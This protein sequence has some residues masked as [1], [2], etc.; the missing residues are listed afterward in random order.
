MS[1]FCVVNHVYRVSDRLRHTSP[2]RASLVLPT[3]AC[4]QK[5]PTLTALIQ[6]LVGIAELC[7]SQVRLAAEFVPSLTQ[8]LERA[9]PNFRK[10]RENEYNDD[11]MSYKAGYYVMRC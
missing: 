4:T 3:R 1:S 5:Y 8:E 10:P 7:P 6:A 9:S 11:L 2:Q